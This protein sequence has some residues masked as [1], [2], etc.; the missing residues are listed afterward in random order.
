MRFLFLSI[1]FQTNP[2]SVDK[3]S[4][5]VAY[6]YFKMLSKSL[7]FIQKLIVIQAF[8]FKLCEQLFISEKIPF[9]AD[10]RNKTF[11]IGSA[12]S[13]GF[14]QIIKEMCLLLVVPQHKLD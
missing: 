9:H 10:I 14:H 1:F 6:T 12:G 2:F 11:I 5:F 4:F 8:F 7:N 13:I 3:Y